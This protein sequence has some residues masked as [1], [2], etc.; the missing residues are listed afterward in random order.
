MTL[1][2]IIKRVQTI[3]GAH[4]QINTFFFGNV[5]NFLSMDIVYPACFMSYPTESIS[6]V[7]DLLSI[8]LFLLDRII[9]GGGDVDKTNNETEVV[10]DMR[11]VAKDLISTLNYQKFTPTW[12]MQKGNVSLETFTETDEDFLGGVKIS[13]SIKLPFDWNRCAVP[14]T[15]ILT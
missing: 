5:D 2:Q 11:E 12:N 14:S 1:N 9:Q 4:E 15:L 3:A 10:S 7:D 6:G 8:E 13:F